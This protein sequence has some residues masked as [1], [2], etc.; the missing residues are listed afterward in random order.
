MKNKIKGRESLKVSQIPDKVVR[1]HLLKMFKPEYLKG[2]YLEDI[3][4][5]DKGWYFIFAV[6]Y[7]ETDKEQ[8]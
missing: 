5:T 8:S 1:E 4:G 3:A 7:F 2:Y 6:D